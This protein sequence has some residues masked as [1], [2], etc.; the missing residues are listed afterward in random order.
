MPAIHVRELYIDHRATDG[1][2]ALIYYRRDGEPWYVSASMSS[3]A[4]YAWAHRPDARWPA[5][6]LS[7]DRIKSVRV[8]LEEGDLVDV[9]VYGHNNRAIREPDIDGRELTAALDDLVVMHFGLPA[10]WLRAR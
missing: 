1:L 8:E 2:S 6:T 10:T 4:L 9:T 7:R 3:D 5:S